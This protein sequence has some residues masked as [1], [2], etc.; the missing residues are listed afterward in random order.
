MTTIMDN[1]IQKTRD[2]YNKI[3]K[4]F[5][6]TRQRLWDELLVFAPLI[7]DGQNIL[8]WG[9]GSGRLI[10]LLKDKK[11]KYFGLDQSTELLKAAKAH[12][13]PEIKDG[14]VKFFCTA[15]KDKKF[16]PEFFDWV[17]MI[18]SFHHL[19]DRASRLKLLRKI[20]REMRPGAK[21]VMANWNLKSDWIVKKKELKEIGENDFFITWKNPQG[22][23]ETELYYHHFEKQELADLLKKA[24]FEVEKNEYDGQ[25]R[26]LMT[27]AVRLNSK[28]KITNSK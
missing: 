27:V 7:K 17:F 3:A 28:S 21:L 16:E 26:N 20:Y 8:D 5:S 13:A 10:L 6:A 4:H 15:S 14:R 24:G 22:I 25:N 11:I 19:P 18:A 2:S 23:A 12:Y 9:C 1:I